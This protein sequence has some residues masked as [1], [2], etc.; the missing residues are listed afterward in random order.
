MLFLGIVNS[1]RTNLIFNKLD[2][3]NCMYLLERQQDKKTFRPAPIF[4][5]VEAK[6]KKTLK[7]PIPVI[8]R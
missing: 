7:N 1:V 5:R 6:Y 3:R 4:F 8:V 2:L